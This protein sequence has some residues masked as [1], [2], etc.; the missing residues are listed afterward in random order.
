MDRTVELL[1]GIRNTTIRLLDGLSMDALN[2]IPAGFNNNLVWNFAHVVVS[3]Q[4]LCYLRGGLKPFLPEAL[5]AK[6]QRG[7]R[8][9]QWVDRQAFEQ[10][11]QY[12]N[13]ALLQLDRDLEKN[14]FSGIR[15]FVLQTYGIEVRDIADVLKM[16]LQHEGL[17]LGY[18][19]ALKHA[20]PRPGNGSL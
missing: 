20:L 4:S 16:L 13:E 1:I 2:S 14:I 3:Q 7:T 15:P 5:I 18:C 11:K 19:M 9:E 17:H 10:L 12:S 6:Y 8:P